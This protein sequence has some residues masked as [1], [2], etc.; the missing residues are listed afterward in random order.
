MGIDSKMR[1]LICSLAEQVG[2]VGDDVRLDDDYLFFGD[3]LKDASCRDL[4]L[5]CEDV[6]RGLRRKCW[7]FSSGPSSVAG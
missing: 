2:V 5:M 3:G 1:S 4:R 7:V 6:G